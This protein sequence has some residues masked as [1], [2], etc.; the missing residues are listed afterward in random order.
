LVMAGMTQS[1]FPATD[2]INSWLFRLT[3]SWVNFFVNV[4]VKMQK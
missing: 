3:S 4:I 2:C 1:P